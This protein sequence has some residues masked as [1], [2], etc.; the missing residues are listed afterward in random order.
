MDQALF[1]LLI[2]CGLEAKRS[3][4][5]EV[6]VWRLTDANFGIGALGKN[7]RAACRDAM[8]RPPHLPDL[9]EM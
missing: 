6:C 9:D 2:G 5:R 4:S 7:E 1:G 3:M 8:P